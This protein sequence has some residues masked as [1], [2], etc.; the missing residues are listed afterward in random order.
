[1]TIELGQTGTA[2]LWARHRDALQHASYTHTLLLTLNLP[3]R[4]PAPQQRLS[5]NLPRLALLPLLTKSQGQRPMVL[6]QRADG[7]RQQQHRYQR[8]CQAKA[9]LILP[10]T[11]SA[12]V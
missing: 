4:H 11:G 10:A 2:L 1:M 8:F 3:A 12:P 9:L 5:G 7:H 6:Q